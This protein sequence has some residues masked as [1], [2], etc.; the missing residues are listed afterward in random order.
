MGRLLLVGLLFICGFASADMAFKEVNLVSRGQ[1]QLPEPTLNGSDWQWLRHKRTLVYGTAAPNYPPFDITTG[2]QDY[3]GINADYLG[4]IAY[5]LNMQIQVRYYANYTSLIEALHSG[6][7]DMIANA[8]REDAEKYTL[9]LTQPYFSA[10]PVLVERTDSLLHHKPIKDIAIERLYSNRKALLTRFPDAGHQIFDSPRRALEALSFN[11]LDA[12]IGDSTSARYLINQAN[13]NNLRL[14]LLPQE[15][16]S[17]FSFGI[18]PGNDRLQRVLNAV[19]SNIPESADA[20]IESRWSGGIPVSAAARHLLFTS[21]ERKWIEEKP[22][23]RVVVNDDFAP[24]SFF[25]QQDHLRGLTADVLDAIAMRTGLKFNIIRANSLRDSLAEVKAGRA[26]V[27]AGV[28]LDT[29]WPNGLLTTRSY[30]FNSW[31]LVGFAEQ[32]ENPALQRIALVTGHPLKAFLQQRYPRSRIVSVATPQAGIETIKNG[33][34]DALVLPMISADFLLSHEP[35]VG[36]LKILNGLDTEPARFVMGVSGSEYPLATILDKAL[37]NIPP[38]EIHTMI[39]NWYSN[40]YLMKEAGKVERKTSD[41]FRP[42]SGVLAAALLLLALA[43][44]ACWRRNKRQLTR[45]QHQIQQRQQALLDALPLPVYMTDFSERIVAANQRFH[46]AVGVPVPQALGRTLAEYHLSVNDVVDISLQSDRCDPNALMMTRQLESAGQLRTL[47]QWSVL[48][49]AA[50]RSAEGKVGGWFD[51]TE[52]ERLIAELQH[53]KNHADNANRAKT[54]FLTT[55]SHEI[56]TPLNAI[57]G[58]LE[59][60]LRQE[61]QEE[62]ANASLLGIAYDSAHSLLVLIGDILDISRIESERLILHPERADLQRLIESVAVLFDGVARQKGLDF[63]LEMDAEVSGDVLIDP[64]RFKQILSNLVSNAI[65]FTDQ[66]RVTLSAM[67]ESAADDRLDIRINIADTGKGIGPEMQRRLFQPFSQG[68]NNCGGAGLGLY[69]SRT[70]V[71]MMGGTLVLTS[72]P[73]LGSEFTVSLSIPRLM[74]LVPPATVP[75]NGTVEVRSLQ[76]LVVEDHR[77]GRLLLMQQL[78]YLGHHAIAAE[79]GLQAL[80]MLESHSFD[81]IITDCHMPNMDGY[82]FVRQLRLNERERQLPAHRVWGVTANA[83]DSARE[84]CLQAGMDDC[85]FKPMNLT[86]LTEKLQQIPREEVDSLVKDSLIF[87][88]HC[89]PPELRQPAIFAE[90]TRTLL[91]CLQE[92]AEALRAQATAYP[93]HPESLA[94]LA[95]KLA[96][97]AKLVHADSLINAC[98]ALENRTE[99][100]AVNAVL[101]EVERLSTALQHCLRTTNE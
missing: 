17:G 32:K 63:K 101:V 98:Q 60:A 100:D 95:H 67:V 62:P 39:R 9:L 24:L 68:H 65:K 45:W 42:V 66:G 59:L 64:L 70:L 97:A 75:D 73:Q 2:L 43:F 51:I 40:A 91:V 55:M 22:T 47:Q 23:V 7:V 81:L 76:V 58:M 12:F 85:L 94:E 96:G 57:I 11:N 71:E 86:I 38:E 74:H 27:I 48:L 44:I 83:Q 25:D 1:V 78:R 82:S 19:L 34:A 49:M 52:R 31:V 69:I 93:L 89:L 15:D 21:L 4:I 92:D 87:D 18:A 79:D 16:V 46:Q 37:L 56:R 90:F 84:A 33:Q 14:Q 30:L 20:A 50:G 3:G 99:M 5:N 61:P 41:V 35:P 13:L 26:D 72:E 10:S 8:S 28:T 29:V 53:A 6:H 80:A 54:T 88:R 36:G 77:A